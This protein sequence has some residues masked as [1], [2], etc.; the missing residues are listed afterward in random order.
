MSDLARPLTSAERERL[1]SAWKTWIDSQQ[2]AI[3]TVRT[4]DAVPR[5]VMD[6]AEGYRWVT[7]LASL[8]QEWFVEKADPL[9]PQLFQAQTEYRKLLVDNPD[10]R[11]GFCSLDEHQTYRLV[12]TRGE[13]AYVGLTFGTPFGKGQV[14]GRTGTTVQAHIDQFELGP[15]GEVDIL[16]VPEGKA[17]D[18]RPVNC[19]EMGP[20]TGQLA[21]RETFF[22]RRTEKPSDL[23]MELVGEVA[24]PVLGV[25]ELAS[26]L[27]FAGLFVQFV[28][29]TAVNMWHDTAGNVNSF[30]GTSGAHHVAAQEDENRSHSN[31]EMTYHGARWVL[32]EGEALVVTVHQPSNEFLY[33]GLTTSTAWM[34]SLDYRYTTTNLNNR[35]AKQS[36]DGDW[37]LVISPTDPGVP[38]WIDTQGR[39][40]GYMIVRWVLA[41]DPPHPT[42][43]LM[44]IAQVKEV[45]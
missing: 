12:G 22:D 21:V 18:P 11:Y 29:A 34:E 24:P 31:P 32:G 10:T 26:T 5:T 33:W 1:D 9:H 27:E 39:R 6:E 7:R 3:E 13:A 20:G 37:R 2:A 35:T 38:N 25:E 19:V 28:A 44:P 36:D 15:N 43:E 45:V 17:P 16:I 42:A 30:G 14:A 4:A 40:E 41:D 8:A 23:R